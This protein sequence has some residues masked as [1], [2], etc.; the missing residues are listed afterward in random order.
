MQSLPRPGPVDRS[1][2]SRAAGSCAGISW[3][4]GW[5]R[6]E[7]SRGSKA[8]LLLSE[9]LKDRKFQR[10]AT[11]MSL[12]YITDGFTDSTT[13]SSLRPADCPCLCLR[14]VAHIHASNSRTQ[15]PWKITQANAQNIT[16][17]R[18]HKQRQIPCLLTS[19]LS[20][21]LPL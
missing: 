17:D 8:T 5:M 10:L 9:R 4:R 21:A 18:N 14:I 19:E 13:A 20:V 3:M 15:I 12:N 2:G 16:L 6:G 7:T 11:K 1:A